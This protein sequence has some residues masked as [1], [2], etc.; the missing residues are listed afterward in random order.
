MEFKIVKLPIETKGDPQKFEV[1]D[2]SIIKDIN[3]KETKVISRTL[4]YT[5]DDLQANIDKIMA[6]IREK[7]GD[8]LYYQ[9]IQRLIN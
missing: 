6:E 8:I 5:A 9:Q 1:S 2:I 7:K 3:N 4:T